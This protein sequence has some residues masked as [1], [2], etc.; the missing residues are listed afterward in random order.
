MRVRKVRLVISGADDQLRLT[1]DVGNN[2]QAVQGAGGGGPVGR[3]DIQAIH[4][5]LASRTQKR[6]CGRI[7]K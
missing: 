3:N 4:G 6:M 2:A 1:D 5:E 7:R